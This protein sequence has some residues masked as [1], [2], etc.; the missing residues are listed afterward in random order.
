[1]PAPDLNADP[2]GTP[3]WLQVQLHF[4]DWESAATVATTHLLPVLQTATAGG[5]TWWFIR[6][7][8][9][10]RVRLNLGTRDRTERH[11]QVA[12]A[13]D[14]LTDDGILRGWSTGHYEP[15]TTAFGG[16]EA[17][18]AAH[19]LFAADS[20]AILCPVPD[21]PLGPRELSMLCCGTLVRGAR[22][23]P[24]EIG[25]VWARVTHDRP[26][27]PSVAPAHLDAVVTA[28]Q[29][30]LRTD[31]APDGNAFGDGGLLA[32]SRGR[33]EAFHAC[34]SLLAHLARGGGLQRGLRTILAYH[35][36]FHWNRV[37]LSTGQQIL[38]AHAARHAILGPPVPADSTPSRRKNPPRRAAPKIDVGHA[39][40][41]F[42]LLPPTRPRCP[43]LP[44]RMQTVRDHAHAATA[45]DHPDERVDRACSAWNLAALI[46]ADG[47]LPGLAADLSH[48]QF[49]LL[50][51]AWPLPP[52]IAIAALQ[53]LINLAR[54]HGRG[55]RPEVMYRLLTDIEHG[56]DHDDAP[57]I[58]DTTITLDGLTAP[59]DIEQ[60]RS[61]YRT[62]LLRDGT[63]ALAATA[64][65]TRAAAHAALHD[66]LPERLQAARQ[67]RIIALATAGN[68]TDALA[69]LDNTDPADHDAPIAVALR[70]IVNAAAGRPHHD[71]L[72]EL[73]ARLSDTTAGTGD[74][75]GEA[76]LHH[77]R[78]AH[79]ADD[80]GAGPNR[81]APLWAHLVRR[82]LE[83]S[84]A[85][86][87]QEAL[88]ARTCQATLTPT[89][90]TALDNLVSH[91]GI[92][93]PPLRTLH[94][95]AALTSPLKTA[96]AAL[97]GHGT[98]W[99]VSEK[100]C[101]GEATW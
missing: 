62:V 23:E 24:Y 60:V 44:E 38:L 48:Q 47:G 66:P 16:P 57:P 52:R 1:M 75:S 27:P 36:L 2:T 13:L 34:G 63:R 35:V 54:L 17:M 91:A 86:A 80:L 69:V 20:R 71:G 50:C 64:E 33:A 92:G 68:H 65:W 42:P 82:I 95:V 26:L 87:A 59:H 94:A 45:S 78:L 98:S 72:T 9:H 18:E 88:T 7:H 41:H 74:E 31:P 15:E 101:S 32:S 56:L 11:A 70:T 76:T 39:S 67:T 93:G 29:T 6:K 53:P 14:G 21:L 89:H 77:V 43:P 96:T 55:N 22:L 19:T 100:G 10:W 73:I 85:Y 79:I 5:G 37:G 58:H 25:D 4:T 99:R 8:P 51:T 97:M 49:E 61:W 12:Q 3:D 46:A 84:E 28:V 81:M 30:I 40:R 83:T 90:A